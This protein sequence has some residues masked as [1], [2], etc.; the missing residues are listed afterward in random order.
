MRVGEIHKE[1]LGVIRCKCAVMFWCQIN[2]TTDV[3]VTSQN[4]CNGIDATVE[5]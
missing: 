3:S 1:F 2:E 5:Q 4:V